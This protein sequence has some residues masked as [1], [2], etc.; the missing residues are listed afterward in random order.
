M[1]WDNDTKDNSRA[2]EDDF[3][4]DVAELVKHEGNENDT[5]LSAYVKRV[6]PLY[7]WLK[8]RKQ[9][10]KKLRKRSM[11]IKFDGGCAEMMKG[12]N[13]HVNSLKR[14]HL[15]SG[16]DQGEGTIIA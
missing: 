15:E 11:K 3:N 16:S 6:S 5:G 2:C 8:R 1:R 7:D 4:N 9:K 13:S 14:T 10:K 12:S